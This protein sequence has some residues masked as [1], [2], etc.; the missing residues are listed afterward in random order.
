MS[1][2]V[3]IYDVAAASGY[4]LATISRVLN[5]PEKV[6]PATREKVLKVIEELGYRPNMVARGLAS[7]KTTSVG[8]II[9][10]ITRASV[11][12]MIGGIMDISDTYDYS[13]K[14]FQIHDDIQVK[15]VMRSV[16]AE[17]VD[18]VLY[19][20]DELSDQATEEVKDVLKQSNI[21]YVFTNVINEDKNTA[22]VAID[23]LKAAYDMTKALINKG[24]KH[25]YLLSTA[26]RYT[27]NIA[28]E[29]G[30]INAM[31]ESN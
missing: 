1:N 8:V 20:N 16:V 31:K 4:S 2:N 30:Y 21:P 10:D 13:I 18:G 29:Q 6:K 15:D 22:S 19:L 14:I 27:V 7:R 28:K 17:Q 5:H 23:Y 24:K 9:S 26:R 12:E 25:I 3:T 11:A